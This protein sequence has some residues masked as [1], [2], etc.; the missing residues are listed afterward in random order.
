[1]I[2]TIHQPDFLPWL[3]FFDRWQKSDLFIVLDDVQFLRRGWHHRDKIKAPNGVQWLTVPII[4]K[5]RYHQLINEVEID[6]KDNWRQKHLKTL[7]FSY[8]KAPNVERIF[9]CIGKIYGLKHKL[10]IDFNMDLLKFCADILEIKTSVVLASTFNVKSKSS[11]RLVELVKT[12][13]G[14][15]YLTGSASKAYL[16]ENEFKEAGIEVNWQEFN[17]PVYPQLYN[18][19]EKRLSV[20][21]FFM[22]ASKD[23]FKKFKPKDRRK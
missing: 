8:S 11:Q 12:V 7:K 9:N 19:F 6:N 18:G 3:G 4:K 17:H 10:L 23:D 20:I 21:D 16:D 5:G 22:M 14:D 13:G 1:M 15:T 2:V